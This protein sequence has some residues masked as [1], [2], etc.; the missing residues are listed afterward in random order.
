M[1][2]Q[3]M[4]GKYHSNFSI[5]KNLQKVYL[6]WGMMIIAWVYMW[7]LPLLFDLDI[8]WVEWTIQ[9]AKKSYTYS[10]LNTLLECQKFL[11]THILLHILVTGCNAFAVSCCLS[12]AWCDALSNGRNTSCWFHLVKKVERK[13]VGKS[14]GIIVIYYLTS[15]SWKDKLFH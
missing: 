8:N 10:L 4:M 1:W 3:E 5:R 14:K 13:T 12:W 2:K 11:L 7:D 6:V 9:A 15:R